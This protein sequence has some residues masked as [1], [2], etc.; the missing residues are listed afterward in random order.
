MSKLPLSICLVQGM[1]LV[2]ESRTV[3]LLCVGMVESCTGSVYGVSHGMSLC[4]VA[5]RLSSTSLCRG[6]LRYLF[7]YAQSDISIQVV[8]H[9]LFPVL[10]DWYWSVDGMWT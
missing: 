3:F 10:G 2:N 5:P 8:F 1:Y 7:N 9:F 6:S 4:S